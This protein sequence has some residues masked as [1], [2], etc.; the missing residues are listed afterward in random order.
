MSKVNQCLLM[1][2]SSEQVGEKYCTYMLLCITTVIEKITIANKLTNL[3]VAEQKT[4]YLDG[5]GDGCLILQLG[6]HI[7]TLT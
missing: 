7:L 3:V 5:N 2:H 4:G 6:L 1:N